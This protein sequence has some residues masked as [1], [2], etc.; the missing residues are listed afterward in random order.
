MNSADE[1]AGPFPGATARGDD[2]ASTLFHPDCTVGPGFS[3]DLLRPKAS[4]AGSTRYA[5]YRRS[6]I[7]PCPEG[8]CAEH[9]RENELAPGA[10]VTPRRRSHTPISR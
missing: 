3:P 8:R 2:D 4:L 7:A 9:Q 1:Y 10:L 6:G 5:P